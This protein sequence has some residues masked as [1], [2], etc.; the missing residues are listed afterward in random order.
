MRKYAE[1]NGVDFELSDNGDG[2]LNIT[3]TQAGKEIGWCYVNSKGEYFGHDGAFASGFADPVVE[4][5]AQE[6]FFED[7]EAWL[8]R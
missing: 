8:E 7:I 1:C 3:A 6:V 5:F 4:N 2:V